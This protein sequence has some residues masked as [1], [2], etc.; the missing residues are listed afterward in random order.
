MA[1]LHVGYWLAAQALVVLIL[2][3]CG[4]GESAPLGSSETKEST[5][6]E[7]EP[8][9]SAW[10]TEDEMLAWQER[11]DAEG[12]WVVGFFL[13]PGSECSKTGPGDRIPRFQ[14]VSEDELAP[15]REE[16]LRW[17]LA[18][19]EDSAE[20][21]LSNPL[22]GVPLELLTARVEA[23]TV[24]VDFA[25][26]I[27]ATNNTGSCG[28]SAMQAQFLAVVDHYF[29]QADAACVL[30]EGTPSGEDG[31]ALLFHD[32]RACPLVLSA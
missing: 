6:E 3:G 29:P 12:T 24:Y 11:H 13:S 22:A 16:L 1:K 32:S 25:S 4:S 17:A 7:T 26:G 19:L 20:V 10:L 27:D 14:L 18:A 21:G 30:V 15:T 31:K 8:T 28:G 5:T 23:D 2:A 9:H